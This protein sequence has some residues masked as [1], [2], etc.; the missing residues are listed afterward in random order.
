M[1]Q[2]Q[3]LCAQRVLPHQSQPDMQLAQ[4]R[5]ARSP[6]QRKW[7]LWMASRCQPHCRCHPSWRLRAIAACASAGAHLWQAVKYE[8][9]PEQD[10]RARYH[11]QRCQDDFVSNALCRPC[12][13]VLC[14][15][16]PG[17]HR[18]SPEV[19]GLRAE[20]AA[21][22]LLAAQPAKAQ[23]AGAG[24]EAGRPHPRSQLTPA[25]CGRCARRRAGAPSRWLS[26]QHQWCGLA[27]W[28]RERRGVA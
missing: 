13:R 3:L 18:L 10:P 2:P 24:T 21:R 1:E 5:A 26:A 28:W 23:H 19:P 20:V 6:S 15:R 14:C 25:P 9:L 12:C 8:K 22:S 4:W 16:A 7:P 17:L 11:W 27:T